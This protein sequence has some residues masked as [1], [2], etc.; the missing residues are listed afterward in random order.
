MRSFFSKVWNYDRFTDIGF[1]FAFLLS[2]LMGFLLNYSTM[3]CTKY[4]SPL[5]T[6][7]VGAC[8]VCFIKISFMIISSCSI[9]KEFVRYLSRYVHW[10]RLHFFMGEFYWT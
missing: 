10:W 6:T 1:I 3:L 2:S 8:K 9:L 7:V 4:N 5:T